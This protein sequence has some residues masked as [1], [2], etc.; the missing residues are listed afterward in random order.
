MLK[1]LLEF[2]SVLNAMVS[3]SYET[4]DEFGN[5]EKYKIPALNWDKIEIVCKALEPLAELTKKLSLQDASVADIL[6][7]YHIFMKQW[8]P[9]QLIDNDEVAQIR[10]KV[11]AGL[12]KRM[13]KMK[14]NR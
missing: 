7:I 14:E 6:P 4:R 8:P 2:Q 1:R 9:N 11:T 12:D 13:D 10:Q 3:K 5:K